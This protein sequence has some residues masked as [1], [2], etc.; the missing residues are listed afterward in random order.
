MSLFDTASNLDDVVE[1]AKGHLPIT[2]ENI[3]ISILMTYHN[4][5]LKEI[6]HEQQNSRLHSTNS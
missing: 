6:S 2:S 3:L 5:L 1:W 4:T